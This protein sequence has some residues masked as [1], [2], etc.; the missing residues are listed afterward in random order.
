VIAETGSHLVTKGTDMAKSESVQTFA[1]KANDGINFLIN[2]I[3][4]G[5]KKEEA[6]TKQE[7]KVES[8]GN[9]F[10]TIDCNNDVKFKK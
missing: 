8:K 4:G 7:E 2:S 9:E 3:F 5:K 6:E 10:A 1:K